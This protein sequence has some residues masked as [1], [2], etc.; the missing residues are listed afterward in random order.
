MEFNPPKKINIR[1]I[2][3]KGL[4][5]FATE[6]ILQGETIEECPVF[7]LGEDNTPQSKHFKNYRFSYPKKRNGKDGVIAWGYGSLFNHD[8][9]PNADWEDH[10]KYMGFRFFT[11]RD[12]EKDEEITISYGGNMYWENRA[13]VDLVF[14]EPK[15]KKLF[16][17]INEQE[18]DI[19][20]IKEE[21]EIVKLSFSPHE[22]DK[23][24]IDRVPTL[25]TI[26]EGGYEIKREEF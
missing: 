3:K 14:N 5:V 15:T 20:N 24:N 18:L 9:I 22:F 10:P 8:K 25:L 19:L 4:G 12:I 6:K 1:F 23:Y 17:C 7:S 26:S 21:V 11:L 16:F 2:E 13:G